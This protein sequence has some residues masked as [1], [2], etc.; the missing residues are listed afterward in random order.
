MESQ[1]GKSLGKL[2]ESRSQGKRE[3]AD[4]RESGRKQISG[5]VVVSR[6][7]GKREIAD[8]RENERWTTSTF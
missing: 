2:E 8:L 7:Q 1:R 6:S 5:K 3:I 4:I